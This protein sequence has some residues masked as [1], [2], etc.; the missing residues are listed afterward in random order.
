MIRNP[1]Y[2]GLHVYK[3]K[4]GEI[5][6]QVPA[7]VSEELWQRAND[8]LTRNFRLAKRNGKREYLLR[9]LIR[10]AGCGVR[11]TGMA[12]KRDHRYYRC[13]Y[14][15]N[16]RHTTPNDRC[17]ANK[18]LA[19]DWLEGVVWEDCERFIRDPG[20]ALDEARRQLTERY[21]AAVDIGAERRRLLAKLAG[22]DRERGDIL[23]L[24]RKGT[25]KLDEAEHQLD[26]IAAQQAEIQAELDRLANRQALV[27]ASNQQVLTA[28]ALLADLRSRLVAGVDAATRQA[29]VQALV[30]QIVVRAEGARRQKEARISIEYAFGDPILVDMSKASSPSTPSP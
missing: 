13:A 4:H 11:Y 17:R 19:A 26:D 9:T 14:S 22:K 7:L 8:Q 16:G 21:E 1:I 24:L 27:D 12:D 29:V 23:S 25:I 28:E 3:G 18:N 10:C 5:T 15:G 30:R 20:Q 2:K 6:R